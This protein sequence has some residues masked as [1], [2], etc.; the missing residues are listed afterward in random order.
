MSANF[1]DKLLSGEP[2]KDP[3]SFNDV[4]S[5]ELDAVK[6]RRA[7]LG[8]DGV[9]GACCST[10]APS[11]PV[12]QRAH[13]LE[14]SALCL[15]GGGIR[16]AAFAL[17]IVQALATRGV[18][19][20]FDY[21][22]T[23]SGG[24]YTGAFLTTWVHRAGYEQVAK[25][26]RVDA[27]P[28]PNAPLAYIRRYSKYLTPHAG[29]LSADFLAVLALF[30]RNLFLNWLIIFPFVLAGVILVKL[31]A[32][33]VWSLAQTP[34]LDSYSALFAAI[35]TAYVGAAYVDSLR[36]RPGWESEGSENL[37]FL[38]HELLPICCAALFATIAGA[39]YFLHQS[40]LPWHLIALNIGL[41]G[42]VTALTVWLVAFFLSRDRSEAERKPSTR[43]SL[44]RESTKRHIL[45]T[46]FGFSFSGAMSG[47]VIALMMYV[48]SLLFPHLDA[49]LAIVVFGPPAFI[50][51]L[52]AGELIYTGIT[53]YTPW[54]DGE[55]EWLARAAGYHGLAAGTYLILT[56]LILFGSMGVFYSLSYVHMRVPYLIA[57]AG[58]VSGVTIAILGKAPSTAAMVD[59]EIKSF[60][61]ASYDAIL[62]LATPIFIT[63]ATVLISAGIDYLLFS[64][65]YLSLFSLRK[66]GSIGPAGLLSIIAALVAFGYVAARLVNI[67]RFSL[68]SVYRNRLI[69]AFLGASNN[70]RHPNPFID[71]DERDNVRLAEL[72]PNNV[73][74][75][76]LWP[77]QILVVNMALNVLASTELQLQE[78]RAIPFFATSMWAGTCDR[79]WIAGKAPGTLVRG[80]FRPAATYA[81]GLTLGSAMSISGAAASPNMGYHSSPAL[82]VLLTLFNVRLGAWL[83]NPG[84]EGAETFMRDGPKVA[85]RSLLSEALGLT[86]AKDEYVYLSDGGHFENLGAYEML[87]RRCKRILICDAGCDPRYAYEDLGNLVRKAFIDFGIRIEFRV[88]RG[89]KERGAPSK[90]ASIWIADV[91][92]PSEEA[93]RGDG[94]PK[95]LLVYVKPDIVGSEPASVRAY[96][97]MHP[98]FPHESTANQWFGESQFEAYRALG[99][100]VMRGA[101]L[102][103]QNED[104]SGFFNSL[105]NQFPVG[106][107]E[108]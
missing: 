2:P 4:F 21:L 78:R 62:K 54:A 44:R 20:K 8:V 61:S 26:L 97:S 100:Y 70:D 63:S 51:A 28:A 7:R 108:T 29:L 52:F 98:E 56:G 59:K 39:Y 33:V 64:G 107:A 58:G 14:L 25:A 81:R 5:E 76:D 55:R 105:D 3:A 86:N 101:S 19:P 102:T 1:L 49:E 106:G 90:G 53:S 45:A 82:G 66:E 71:F 88:P 83:G 12:N 22:S 94:C 80:A 34:L 99:A 37:N 11:Q 40:P 93:T 35:T 103:G 10:A 68:H 85:A 104:I 69:R 18:L 23:V 36:Q 73:G 41:T 74:D 13:S 47:L 24:G 87:R 96:L 95:G 46:A 9:N 16:S 67:N 60:R 15:S 65:S 92:Y 50:S 89:A 32:V 6:V 48:T 57:A 43:S 91:Y 27:S 17:G 72:W 77:P 84:P 38:R 30:T 79:E 75:K 42:F 31:L